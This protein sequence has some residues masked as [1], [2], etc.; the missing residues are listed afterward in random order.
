MRALSMLEYTVENSSKNT[1]LKTYE[2]GE[3]QECTSRL[4]VELSVLHH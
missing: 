3:A 1:I 2:Q 4:W